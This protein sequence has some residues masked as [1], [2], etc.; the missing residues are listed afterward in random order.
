[1]SKLAGKKIVLAVTG[2][3]AAYKS[4]LLVRLL[5]KEGAEVRV[6][7]TSS[8]S[9]FISAL[10]LSTLSG[11]KVFSDLVDQKENSWNSHVELGLWAD[12]MLVAPASANTIAKFAGGICDNIITAVYLSARCPVVIAPAMDED[13]WRHPA[14]QSNITRLKSFGNQIIPVG[15]GE[16]ASGLVGQGRMAEPE[17]ILEYLIKHVAVSSPASQKKNQKKKLSGKRALVTAG[18]TYEA[19]DPVRFIGNHSSGKMGIAIAEELAEQ[20]ASVTLV[21]G[22]TS[23]APD[24][25]GVITQR[26][27]SAQEMFDAATQL[28]AKADIA[29]LSAAVADFTPEKAA[30]EKI[31]KG[32]E[33]RLNLSLVKTKD[34]LATLGESKRNGQ[35]LV[36]FALETR[37][38]LKNARKKLR[39]KN[40][41]F[42]VLNSL[43]D[44]GAGFR[45]DTN[46]ITIIDRNEKVFPYQLKSKQ[47]VAADIVN[48]IIQKLS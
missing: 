46:R 18:P 10:T 12:V 47:E 13:M 2:S 14:T 27:T 23:L 48:F 7:M 36:G 30:S 44:A 1:M 42:I 39:K 8:A 5:V 19:I 24:H 9:D 22:P 35:I 25:A 31:K 40:L 6:L 29:V 3:I 26:V 20:G 45:H 41:D 15:E 28:F 21:L 33:D 4:A 38:E 17:E 11:N 32:S 37:D 34:I 43:K 16:L